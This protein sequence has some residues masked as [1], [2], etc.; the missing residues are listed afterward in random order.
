MWRTGEPNQGEVRQT[1]GEKALQNPWEPFPTFP[2]F[3]PPTMLPSVPMMVVKHPPI[4]SPS[5]HRDAEAKTPALKPWPWTMQWDRGHQPC[6]AGL[7]KLTWPLPVPLDICAGSISP[8]RE[9]SAILSGHVGRPCGDSRQRERWT[10]RGAN[11]S[12]IWLFGS[13]SPDPEH[14]NENTSGVTAALATL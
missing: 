3:L 12:G 7:Q 4:L 10:P 14:V 5:S 8:Q 11:S 9:K 13:P 1:Q 2:D 6:E